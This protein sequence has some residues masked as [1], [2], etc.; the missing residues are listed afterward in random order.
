MRPSAYRTWLFLS[1]ATAFINTVVF[2]T[3][4]VYFIGDIGANPLQLVLIG[5]VME[6]TVFLFE[7]PTGAFAD[8]HGRRLSV[9]VAYAIQ[10]FAFLLIGLLTSYA[11]VVVGYIIWGIG[12]TFSSGAL[13][14]WITDEMEGRDLER[15]FLR[16]GQFWSAGQFAGFGVGAVLASIDLSLPFVVGGGL[17]IVLGSALARIMREEHWAPSAPSNGRT[18]PIQHMRDTAIEGVR[19]V[20]GHRLLIYALGFV[21]LVGMFTE[22]VDRLWEAHMLADLEFPSIGDLKPVAWFGII[23]AAGLVL[24]IAIMGSVAKRFTYTEPM[25][26][27]RWLKVLT[28]LQLVGLLTFALA[29]DFY[30]AVIALFL[31]NLARGISG[32]LFSAWINREIESTHRATVLSIVNQS[33]A[34][35]QWVGG[36][37]IGAVGTAFSLRTALSF[38]ALILL[39]AIR[40]M[41]GIQ[42]RARAPLAKSGD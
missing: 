26:S 22:S 38:G 3:A 4:A 17:S 12:A 14:A 1:T 16:G 32:S 11:A 30:V 15:V 29:G 40:L 7:V 19:V 6:I 27:L 8:R 5:T 36:P 20:R 2:T 21:A 35:G 28:W 10:G 24:G 9:S 42:R 23:G 13:E 33:D 39:P 31:M 37:V 41:S 25:E 18:G 34:V